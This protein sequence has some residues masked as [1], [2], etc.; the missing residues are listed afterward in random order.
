MDI[1]ETSL[2]LPCFNSSLIHLR[3]PASFRSLKQGKLTAYRY[4]TT[5]IWS[6]TKG[7][8]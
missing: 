5:G 6:R 2:A 7:R 8:S 1:L 4:E 3:S